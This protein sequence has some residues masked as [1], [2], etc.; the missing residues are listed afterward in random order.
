MKKIMKTLFNLSIVFSLLFCINSSVSANM[1]NGVTENMLDGEIEKSISVIDNGEQKLD[2]IIFERGYILTYED[3][4]EIKIEMEDKNK[5]IPIT[6][7]DAKLLIVKKIIEKEKLFDTYITPSY[8]IWGKNLNA[9]EIALTVLFPIAA[10]QVYFDAQT[11][12]EEAENRYQ[13]NTLYQGNGD[14]FR[15]A[16]WNALMI[17]H[18]GAFKAE[19]FANAHESEAPDG[20]DKTMD[21]FNNS[22]GRYIGQTWNP[23]DYISATMASI[24]YGF[25]YRI[26]DNQLVDTD[27]SGKL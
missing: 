24:D 27:S 16:Y 11:A 20:I 7:K 17:Y 14:A 13:Y 4:V 9:A 22:Y 23:S 15:H 5:N 1:I 18:I 10:I 19:L 21:L 2:D 6:D 12:T 26:I 3:F 25:L 8:T